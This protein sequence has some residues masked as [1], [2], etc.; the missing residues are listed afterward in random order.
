MAQQVLNIISTIFSA[1]STIF[2]IV[3][4]VGYASSERTLKN[5]AWIVADD[6]GEEFWSALQGFHYQNSG[7]DQTTM[8]NRCALGN[9]DFASDVCIPCMR[10]G[11]AAFGLLL[12]ATTFGLFVTIASG[13]L[14][15]TPNAAVQATS[16]FLSFI[17]GVFS[18]VG[19]GLYM[20]NCYYKW[21]DEVDFSL[22]YGPGAIIVLLGLLMMWV[23][24]LLQLGA[25]ALGFRK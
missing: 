18:L 9:D 5:V 10:D 7:A 8:F 16:T 23:T 11:N 4:C 2:F 25:V 13:F 22:H 3:G 14:A 17:S 24:V 12:V 21:D 6:H 20:G 19:F 15:A 1:L